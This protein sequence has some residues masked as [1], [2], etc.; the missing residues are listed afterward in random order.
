MTEDAIDQLEFKIVDGSLS[1]ISELMHTYPRN[2]IDHFLKIIDKR[3]A[4]VL[5]E[6]IDDDIDICY[7]CW[8]TPSY[9]IN[10]DN[11]IL[12]LSVI[13]HDKIFVAITIE[14]RN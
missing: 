10:T 5:Q 1:L 2:H 14:P 9:G 12:T 11:G 4:E 3:R 13:V 7:G 6:M 8:Y